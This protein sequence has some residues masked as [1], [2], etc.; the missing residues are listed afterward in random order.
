MALVGV[1]RLGGHIS[2][3]TLTP[4]Q[5]HRSHDPRESLTN[6]SVPGGGHQSS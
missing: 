2:Y 4:D 3:G 1:A 5:F 6:Y